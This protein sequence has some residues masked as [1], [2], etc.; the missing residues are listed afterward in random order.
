MQVGEIEQSAKRVGTE[1]RLVSQNNHP[2]GQLVPP[3]TP[4][5]GALNG[6]EHAAFRSWICH[7]IHS[8]KV[9]A[10]QFRADRPVA[11]RANRCDLPRAQ[12]LPLR[13]QMSEDSCPAPRQQQFRLSHAR[14]SAGGEDEHAETVCRSF[15]TSALL[16]HRHRPGD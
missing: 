5:C 2:M 8:W 1:M 3:A 11:G 15:D 14:R 4:A 9:Q 10:I 7:T 16:V 6:A 12:S 13:D